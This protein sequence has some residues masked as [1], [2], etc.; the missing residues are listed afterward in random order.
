MRLSITGN[1]PTAT[2]LRGLFVRNGYYVTE[3]LPHYKIH[4]EED[5]NASQITLD[6]VDSEFE[7]EVFKQ[8]RQLATVPVMIDTHG[9]VVHS[10]NEI[11]IVFPPE[12][13]GW[14]ERGVLQGALK[15]LDPHNTRR[16]KKWWNLWGLWSACFLVLFATVA[17][18]GQQIGGYVR[19]AGSWSFTCTAGCGGA[20]PFADNSAF[21]AG[22]TGITNIG[23]VFNDGLGAVTAGNAAAPRITAQRA[24]H[25]NLRR[26]DGTEVGVTAAPLF[27]FGNLTNN[28]AASGSNY[29]A[30]LPGVSTAAA[31]S[32]TEGRGVALSL[33]LSGGLRV[34]CTVGCGGASAFA[35]NSAFTAGTTGITNVGG[36]FNDGLAAVTTGNAAAPRITAQR[37]MHV[38]L[39]N[40]AGTEIATAAAPLRIDPTGGTTQPIS[41]A[42]LPLPTGAAT[43]AEQQTQTTALQLIDDTVN[44]I[45]TALN[46]AQAV[47]AQL[48]DAAPV[49]ATE[50]NI[51]PFRITPQRA[52]HSNLRNQSGTEI[53]TAAAPLKTDPT[54]TTTQP[55]S[56]TVTANQGT[57]AVAANRWLVQHHDGTNPVSQTGTSMNVNCTG[58]CGTPTQAQTYFTAGQSLASAASKDYL[59]LF[60][61]AGSGKILRIMKINLAAGNTAAVAGVGVAM[62]IA[63]TSTVGTTCTAITIR[64]A[65]TTNAAVPAQVT[66]STNCTTDPVTSYIIGTCSINSD[67][68]SA[69]PQVQCYT[70]E[71]SSGQPITLREGQGIMLINTALAPVGLLSP[72]I[73]F[74]M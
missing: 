45:N 54:G 36:V 29:L 28:G 31:P 26:S 42:S 72:S 62:N 15:F 49:A 1:N 12:M 69:T 44:A 16:P 57:A 35:D 41:A 58:G 11:R 8:L 17:A 56:G 5:P 65:D 63:I 19:Q 68:T 70:F 23:G 33:D 37:G 60:N 59:N 39:R 10:D 71:N 48:D 6:S 9:G 67:E 66:S 3:N 40:N 32:Y 25:F 14:V 34:N 73:E 51:A 53:G 21:T 46:K 52:L 27:V 50:D 13:A 22:T 55:V 47:A 20:S 18:S 2:V 43:L 24:I 61:A 30:V 4:L 38:N 64:L 74:T 7:G